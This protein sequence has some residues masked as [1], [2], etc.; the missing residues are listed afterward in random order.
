M[1]KGRLREQEMITYLKINNVSKIYIVGSVGSG[2]T[3]LGKKIAKELDLDFFEMDNLIFERS[4]IEDRKRTDDEINL[5]V[6][7]IVQKDSWLIE[8]TCLREIVQ[9]IFD[10]SSK[11]IF[12]DIFYFV[13]VYR[14]S[15]RFLK[16]KLGIEKAKQY[17]EENRLYLCTNEEEMKHLN[18]TIERLLDQTRLWYEKKY[19]KDKLELIKTKEENRRNEIK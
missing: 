17:E 18:T 13:R 3:T 2:K 14:F 10:S 6:E 16:Q 7:N 11:I 5:L 9:P 15:L 8:G 12:L 19:G 4:S 1:S